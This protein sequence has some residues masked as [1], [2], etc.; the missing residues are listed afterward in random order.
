MQSKARKWTQTCKSNKENSVPIQRS[1]Q[2]KDSKEKVEVV[3]L[4]DLT[5]VFTF[6]PWL[7]K[8][9]NYCFFCLVAARVRVPGRSPFSQLILHETD[10]A[11][12][13]RNTKMFSL[14][15]QT[16]ETRINQTNSENE[17][18]FRDRVSQRREEHSGVKSSTV[19][20][21]EGRNSAQSSH[22][23]SIYL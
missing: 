7:E 18:F 19:H 9:T 10:E 11:K 4:S 22:W 13:A 8:K 15:G 3:A 16:K 14:N 2:R 1:G 6:V 23:V 5:R 12:V 21:K 20:K 17:L